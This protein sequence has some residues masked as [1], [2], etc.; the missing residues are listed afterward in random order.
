MN[1]KNIDSQIPTCFKNTLAWDSQK[2]NE[3]RAQENSY[4]LTCR[5]TFKNVR[6]LKQHLRTCKTNT[7]PTV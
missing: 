5:S 3:D 2:E 6:G 4:C 7:R 1:M